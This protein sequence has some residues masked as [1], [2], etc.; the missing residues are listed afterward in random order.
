M[1]I[2]VFAVYDS[3]TVAFMQPFFSQSS[4]SAM[5]AFGDAANDKQSGLYKHPGDYQLYEIGTF[6]DNEGFLKACVPVKLLGLAADFVL[7][8]KEKDDS[9]SG[10]CKK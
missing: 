10:D 1:I 5:R 7:D 2:R 6:D 4:G 3:K 8:V 9:E